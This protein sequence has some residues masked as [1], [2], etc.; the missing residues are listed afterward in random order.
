MR[1]LILIA[2]SSWVTLS[3]VAVAQNLPNGQNCAVARQRMT[4]SVQLA[5]LCSR[6]VHD[7]GN[8]EQADASCRASAELL[9][10]VAPDVSASLAQAP[11]QRDVCTPPQLVSDLRTASDF[12]TGYLQF[13]LDGTGGLPSRL[14]L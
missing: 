4:D 7:D 12:T 3:T 13:R 5:L 11:A 14:V 10:Q 1:Q 9:V 6:A 2:A 8:V